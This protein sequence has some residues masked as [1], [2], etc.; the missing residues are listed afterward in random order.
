MSGRPHS[1]TRVWVEHTVM[2]DVAEVRRIADYDSAL[3]NGSVTLSAKLPDAKAVV[4]RLPQTYP[5]FG[6]IRLWFEC[7]RCRKRCG[8]LYAPKMHPVIACRDCHNL[9]Y[10]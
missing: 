3:E 6:G 2:V 4:G 10:Y 8:S 1:S 7:P 5:H 9:V